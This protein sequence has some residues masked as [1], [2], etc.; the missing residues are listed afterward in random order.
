[1]KRVSRN[2][3]GIIP[4]AQSDIDT[5]TEAICQ[6]NRIARKRCRGLHRTIR[7]GIDVV[8]SSPREHR[9]GA[10]FRFGSGGARVNTI[11]IAASIVPACIMERLLPLPSVRIALA[12]C[13]G[14]VSSRTTPSDFG[15][16]PTQAGPTVRIPFAPAGSLVRNHHAAL[17]KRGTCA[18]LQRKTGDRQRDGYRQS[19]RG[20]RESTAVTGRI[21]AF[22]PPIRRQGV[23]PGG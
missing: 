2:D 15:P 10:H 22:A 23:T 12:G 3:D 20:W 13:P 7:C 6:G 17:E 4:A 8:R 21:A 14:G 18:P 5:P 9:K 16:L 11:S 19:G 1:V